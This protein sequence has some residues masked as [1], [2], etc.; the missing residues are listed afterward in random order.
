MYVYVVMEQGYDTYLVAL[1]STLEFAFVKANEYIELY[2]P[3]G[4]KIMSS[5]WQTFNYVPVRQMERE[6]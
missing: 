2:Q 5:V 3:S 6:R 4:W 1:C